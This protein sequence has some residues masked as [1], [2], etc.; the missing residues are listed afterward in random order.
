M[1]APSPTHP[2]ARRLSNVRDAMGAAGLDGLVVTHLP[3]IRYLT[4]FEG[5]AGVV[6]VTRSE[7]LLGVDFRYVTAARALL[8]ARQDGAVTLH[9][10]A[11]TRMRSRHSSGRSACSASAS[12]R[13][14]WW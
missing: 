3:N 5:S 10:K 9:L 2:A 14:R 8:E 7:C 12:R 13:R 6:L 11:G 4:G 1:P